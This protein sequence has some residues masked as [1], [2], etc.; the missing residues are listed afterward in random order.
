MTRDEIIAKLLSE[1]PSL[2]EAERTRAQSPF[3]ELYIGECIRRR[4]RL[5]RASR[6]AM[7]FWLLLNLATLLVLLFVDTNKDYVLILG[8]ALLVFFLLSL[9]WVRAAFVNHGRNIA[10]LRV[11]R[12]IQTEQDKKQQ[13]SLIVN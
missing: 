11:I 2:T 8:I 5:L 7:V 6:L 1:C 9:A 4:Q 13:E 10:I 3:D 12:A